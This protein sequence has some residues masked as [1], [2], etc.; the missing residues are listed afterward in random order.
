MKVS[1]R[2]DNRASAADAPKL[3][4]T[5]WSA[6]QHSV[7]LPA[8][9][10]AGQYS[11][12]T[13][14]P[15][16]AANSESLVYPPSGPH[17]WRASDRACLRATLPA[18]SPGALLWLRI[19][20]A[21]WLRCGSMGSKVTPACHQLAACGAAERSLLLLFARSRTRT[22]HATGTV[23]SGESPI[24]QQG[25]SRWELPEVLAG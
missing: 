2:Q 23:A 10:V 20:S 5:D 18:G 6:H 13:T 15:S 17:A 3:R 16:T 24:K 21:R 4:H 1:K 12:T 7:S 8:G 9:A 19:A 25:Y 14:Y 22:H 11:C